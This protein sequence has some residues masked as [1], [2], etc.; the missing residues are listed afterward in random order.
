MPAPDSSARQ[1]LPHPVSPL[2]QSGPTTFSYSIY[3]PAAL[4]IAFLLLLKDSGFSLVILL[5]HPL[6]DTILIVRN[7]PGRREQPNSSSALCP[8]LWG[9][10]TSQALS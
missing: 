2:Y 9:P 5:L 1:S 6:E 3:C 4:P 10:H 7:S 8:A